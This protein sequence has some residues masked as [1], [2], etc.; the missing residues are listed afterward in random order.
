MNKQTWTAEVLSQ[1]GQPRA[2]PP[3][4]AEPPAAEPFG[5]IG[6][7]CDL[8]AKEAGRVLREAAALRRFGYPVCA[9]I[10]PASLPQGGGRVPF[11]PLD[12]AAPPDE[13]LLDRLA[14]V[15]LVPSQGLAAKLALGIADNLA[16]W[17]PLQAL[18]RGIPVFLDE[19]PVRA[20]LGQP[21]VQ[22]AL[23]ALYT[24]YLTTLRSFGALPI[25]RGQYLLTMLEAFRNRLLDSQTASERE[26]ATGIPPAAGSGRQVIT[27]RDLLAH[28]E[29]AAWTLPAG[30]L[31]TPL[32]RDFAREKGIRLI[33]E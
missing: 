18:W 12:P 30:T 6:V 8:P 26:T 33:F 25:A 11:T 2:T 4:G 31:V 3:A 10:A 16:S 29:Q 23:E 21:A 17:L 28:P 22:P 14:A 9:V 7:V 5:R 13:A 20:P 1:I 32:A 19:Q 15:L 24:G 27:R